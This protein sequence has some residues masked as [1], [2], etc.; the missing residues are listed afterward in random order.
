MSAP[1]PVTIRIMTAESGSRRRATGAVKSPDA[2]QVNTG[3]TIDRDSGGSVMSPQTATNEIAKDAIIA[4]QATAPDAPL[5]TRRPK[6]ALTRNPASGKSGTR[7][8]I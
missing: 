7:T 3:V 1:I 8:T 5:L 4:A 2:I 6:L